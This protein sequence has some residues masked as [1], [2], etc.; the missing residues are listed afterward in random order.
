MV[1]EEVELNRVLAWMLGAGH[2]ADGE[3]EHVQSEVGEAGEINNRV[4]RGKP[5]GLRHAKIWGK[6]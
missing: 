1:V 2:A 6:R 4:A 3:G 5:D